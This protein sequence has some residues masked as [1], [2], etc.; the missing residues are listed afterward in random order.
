MSASC[1][2]TGMLDPWLGSLYQNAS[3]LQADF[4]EGL[5]VLWVCLEMEFLSCAY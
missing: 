1:L 2:Y 4:I 3:I 5:I